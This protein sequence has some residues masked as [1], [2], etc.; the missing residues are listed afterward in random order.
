MS[1]GYEAIVIGGGHNGLAAG[2]YLARDGLRTVV[3][4]ARHKV[5]GAA[6]TDAP[7]VEAP[8][9]RVT[10]YSYVVSLMPR[11]IIDELR[12]ERHG[13]EVYPM[14]P[15][16][17]AFPDGRSLVITGTDG[18]RDYESMARFSRKDAETYPGWRR[19]LGELAA[20]MEPLLL[21]TPPRLGSRRPGDL[22]EQLKLA[23]RMRGLDVSRVGELT[24]L[25]T[26][27]AWD[28]LDDWFESPQIKGAMAVDGIIGTWAGPASPGTAY[29]LMH[30]EIGDAGLG[31]SSWGYPRGGMGAVSDALRSSA[32][33]FGAEV[34]TNAPVER[35]LQR[36]GRVR[37]VV[38]E[39]GEELEAGLVVAAT[40]PRKTFLEQ[41]G[42]EE[43]P[44]DFVRDIER[45]NSRSGV[46][47]INLALAELPDFAA[48]PGPGDHLG[49]AIEL[50]HS[51]DYIE[52]AFQ[53]A[54]R[55]V[56]ARRPFSDG[57][58]PTVFD[59]TLCPEGYHM[60]S[61]FTQWVPHEWSGEPRREELEAYADRVIDG[62]A[63]LAPNLKEAILHRQVLGPYDM[64][65]EL[66]LIGGNIFH[67]ELSADQLFH[68]RPVPG[69]ADYRTPIRGLYQ[70]SS[71]T[72]AGGGVCAIPA[73]NCLR[74][75]R[76]D[77]RR[78][79]VKERLT[80]RGRK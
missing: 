6:A 24:R 69:Y 79:N 27:S 33:E 50:A 42:R 34:R 53:D 28:L 18:R 48:D 26:M 59:R 22:L 80:L 30:H 1:G 38:L 56:A 60:M 71:A 16:Y 29:V 41:L 10:T 19:W 75:I 54:R 70:A 15:S 11:R 7:W 17:Y 8:E 57:V 61:L 13:Y 47:K 3:L 73:R 66:G 78:E 62:Y 51:I 20:I 39:G 46:V 74:E 58:I 37:G 72:H 44:G 52:E 49:G 32:E 35:I 14:G 68:M 77:R 67:G 76:R 64:E 43:L 55:G 21:T 25:M 31:L 5:G 12:L 4:E 63:E 40:H 36:D 9:F 45:W 23:W 65:Q 2:A